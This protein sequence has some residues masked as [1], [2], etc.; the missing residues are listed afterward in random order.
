[1]RSP[2]TSRLK[3]GKSHHDEIMNRSTPLF[4]NDLLTGSPQSSAHILDTHMTF[5]P[6]QCRNCKRVFT[7]LSLETRH[8]RQDDQVPGSP[9]HCPNS[10]VPDDSNFMARCDVRNAL[11]NIHTAQHEVDT[12]V[13]LIAHYNGR[14]E[15]RRRRVPAA[16][17]SRDRLASKIP[18][19]HADKIPPENLC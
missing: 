4:G 16:R 8:L 10:P 13:R 7:R 9:R 17:S 11:W 19:P 12:A 2:S 1:M 14:L 3:F 15:E 18:M 6:F 5:S